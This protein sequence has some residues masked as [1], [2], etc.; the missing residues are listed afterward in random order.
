MFDGFDDKTGD[1]SAPPVV[2][3]CTS[4]GVPS[5]AASAAQPFISK[6]HGWRLAREVT[7]GKV[8]FSWFCPPCWQGRGSQV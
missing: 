7:Q 6:K 4:C 1:E 5:P 3:K 2:R 8:V